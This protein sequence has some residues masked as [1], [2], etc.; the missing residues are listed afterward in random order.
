MMLDRTRPA[1]V[2]LAG[3][4]MALAASL[5]AIAIPAA[6]AP[7]A[8][9]LGRSI[10]FAPV[11]AICALLVWWLRRGRLFPTSVHVAYV[12]LAA[13]AGVVLIA[14]VDV[15]AGLLRP[16]TFRGISRADVI[17]GL[18]TGGLAGHVGALKPV[19]KS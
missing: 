4:A 6:R 2:G 3:A 15:A 19:E 8:F 10:M 16:D 17:V 14:V 13:V 9:A 7:I 11:G 18:L 1:A 12:L 5:V